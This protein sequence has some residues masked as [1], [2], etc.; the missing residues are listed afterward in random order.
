MAG[1]TAMAR[2]GSGRV[3]VLAWEPVRVPDVESCDGPVD[4][5]ADPCDLH[6]PPTF[7][8][9]WRWFR[10][11]VGMMTFFLLDPESWR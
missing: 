11:E 5:A 4:L 9:R 6:P 2:V 3:R 7:E 8:E 1:Y 10:E